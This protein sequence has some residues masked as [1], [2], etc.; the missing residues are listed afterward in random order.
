V[1]TRFRVILFVDTRQELASFPEYRNQ[2][3]QLIEKR[4]EG[5]RVDEVYMRPMDYSA[6]K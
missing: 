2:A 5:Y 1:T 6:M 3:A 4:D